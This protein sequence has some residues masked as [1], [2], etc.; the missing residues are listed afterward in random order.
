[1]IVK[2]VTL[3]SVNFLPTFIPTTKLCQS[4]LFPPFVFFHL[5]TCHTLTPT[6]L[7]RAPKEINTSHPDIG[8]KSTTRVRKFEITMNELIANERNTTCN[9]RKKFFDLYEKL[10]YRKTI[11][12]LVVEERP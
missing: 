4:K 8:K 5:S 10:F 6:I 11:S 12:E 2:H 1:M 3:K 7:E 9:S